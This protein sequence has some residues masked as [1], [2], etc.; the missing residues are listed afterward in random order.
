MKKLTYGRPQKVT[1]TFIA[2]GLYELAIN[3]EELIRSMKEMTE[4]FEFS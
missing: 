4:S 2:L 1:I 3:K